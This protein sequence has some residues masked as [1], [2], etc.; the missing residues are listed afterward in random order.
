MYYDN[1][2]YFVVG[3][4]DSCITTTCEN[5]FQQLLYD[6]DLLAADTGR[7][8]IYPHLNFTCDV[9]ITGWKFIGRLISYNGRLTP[10]S[11]P[12]LQIWEGYKD[13]Y[14][15]QYNFGYEALGSTSSLASGQIT[16]SLSTGGVLVKR[17]QI[18]GIF[19]PQPL[20]SNTFVDLYFSQSESLPPYYYVL[21]HDNTED[22]IIERFNVSMATEEALMVPQVTA[23]ICKFTWVQS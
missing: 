21:D 10:T 18:F 5:P 13:T 11:F 19:V 14:R 3:A 6:I 15:L 9:Y 2:V 17:G 12:S 20:A 8:Y 16:Y 4:C 23:M 22:G 1:V 7:Q